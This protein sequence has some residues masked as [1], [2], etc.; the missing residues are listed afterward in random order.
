MQIGRWQIL[1]TIAQGTWSTVATAKPTNCQSDTA[2]YVIKYADVTSPDF[3]IASRMLARELACSKLISHP[4]IISFLDADVDHTTPYLVSARHSGEKF[5]DIITKI[6]HF[7]ELGEKLS[8]FRQICDA[9]STL[10]Q[11]RIRHGDLSPQNVIVNLD[12]SELMIVDLGLSEQ[13]NEFKR[14]SD[15][16]A[17]TRGYYAPECTHGQW[18]VG[19]SADI[20]SIGRMMFELFGFAEIKSELHRSRFHPVYRQIVSLIDQMI[21]LNP[22][23]RPTISEVQQQVSWLEILYLDL[24]YRAAA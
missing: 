20:Y 2:D 15:S 3:D 8:C 16:F 1:E 19:L 14:V 24:D 23:K 6:K 7:V 9:V 22:L 5:S 21:S 13:V 17:G 18:P 12:D 4:S 10:H 11:L